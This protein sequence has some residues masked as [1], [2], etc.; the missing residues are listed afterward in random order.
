M[1]NRKEKFGEVFTPHKISSDLVCTIPTEKL[2][3]PHYCFVEPNCGTGNI[4]IQMLRWRTYFIHKKLSTEN[5][6]LSPAE[7]K[8]YSVIFA[9]NTTIAF[10][11]QS[12]NVELCKEAMLKWTL[13]NVCLKIVS[14]KTLKDIIDANVYLN[15]ALQA[16]SPDLDY[17]KKLTEK[18]KVSKDWFD[19]HGFNPIDL[20]R[21]IIVV[22]NPPY[23]EMDG[24]H[25]KSSKPIYQLFIE[26]MMD[27]SRVDE[28]S[29]VIP[30]RW[31]AGGKGLLPFRKKI[32]NCGKIKSIKYFEDSKNVFPEVDI[33]GGICFLNW[34]SGHKSTDCDFTYG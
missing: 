20:K 29:V 25:G 26:S 23:Q 4:V 28:F 27:S 33:R 18:T 30:A 22:G 14:L 5:P 3:S 7:R 32:Q 6:T 34:D 1:T 24:G 8:T 31:F 12:D 16:F 10:D 15:E 17:A 19:I 13:D 11:I 21:K 2:S 9:L